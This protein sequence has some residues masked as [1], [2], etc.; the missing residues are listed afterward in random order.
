M[1]NNWSNRNLAMVAILTLAALIGT[2][3]YDNFGANAQR[4]APTQQDEF[5]LRPPR[6]CPAWAK[7]RTI[8][9]NSQNPATPGPTLTSYLQ[10]VTGGDK[11]KIRA[12]GQAGSDMQFA[13][14]FDIG[15][16]RL[17]AARL[18]FNL[19]KDSGQF[20]NDGFHLYLEPDTASSTLP[21]PIFTT[22]AN[23][24]SVFPNGK[25][26]VEWG[27]V[28]TSTATN[29]TQR[30]ISELNSYIF[31]SLLQSPLLDVYIQD[32]TRIMSSRLTVWTY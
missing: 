27:K 17:C 10:K 23:L 2:A 19:V 7:P 21:A 14:S 30:P 25:P 18:E 6:G 13:D 9:R 24:W 1:K 4:A 15:R 26:V 16:C 32:D 12:Y 5:A 28:F 3:G 22:G 31:N 29:S 8:N 20:D 11:T